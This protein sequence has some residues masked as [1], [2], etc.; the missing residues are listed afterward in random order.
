[1]EGML[2][3]KAA[4]HLNLEKLNTGTELKKIHGL[5]DSFLYQIQQKYCR[6]CLYGE[7]YKTIKYDSFGSAIDHVLFAL[8]VPI[9]YGY[10]LA[11]LGRYTEIILLYAYL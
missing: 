6:G 2:Y 4:E 5:Q 9:R 3:P 7:G 10:Q 1:M 8:D 11:P